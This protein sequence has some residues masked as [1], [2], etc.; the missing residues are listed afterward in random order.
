MAG[1]TGAEESKI[2]DEG[3]VQA[4]GEKRKGTERKYAHL[5]RVVLVLSV[6]FVQ[7]S[8]AMSNE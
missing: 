8:V 1:A 5:G 6:R 4:S 2:I 3:C 7:A